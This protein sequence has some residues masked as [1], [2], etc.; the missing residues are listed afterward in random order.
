MTINKNIHFDA[1]ATTPISDGVLAVMLDTLQKVPGNP[2]SVTSAGRHA[3]AKIVSARK[4]I[5]NFLNISSEEIFFTSGGTESIQTL[6]HGICTK[7]SGPIITTAIEHKAV[8]DCVEKLEKKVVTLDTATN[9]IYC[10]EEIENHLQKGASAL[11]LS[12][13]NGETG[14]IL[15]IEKIAALAMK[16]AT[17]LIIDGVAALGKM[18]IVLYDGITAMAFSGHKIHGPK[19]SGFCFLKKGTSFSPLFTG[20]K[21]E[22]SLR[23][24]TENTAAILGLAQ[25]V[26]EITPE[27][28]NHLKNLRDT[29]ETKIKELFPDCIVHTSPSRICNVSN[30]HFPDID[31]DHMLIHLDQNNISASLG[32]ACSS[33]ALEPSHVLLGLGYRRRHATSSLRFSFHK[34]NTLDEIDRVI[35]ILKLYRGAAPY[36]A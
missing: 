12:L 8:L 3:K 32:S 21:Q 20:G 23:A 30:I 34:H 26:S 13:V 2:S 19:G 14:A 1:N 5:A 18:P 9:D 17:A 33:G 24:G 11:I 15:P 31:G 29:F 28:Y 6:I 27:I 16:Y 35:E 10:L 4:D 7:R 25:A 36:P 22:Q